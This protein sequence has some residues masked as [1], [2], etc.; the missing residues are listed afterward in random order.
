M[1][2]Y[3]VIE[4]VLNREGGNRIKGDCP[5]CKLGGIIYEY[6]STNEKFVSCQFCGYRLSRTIEIDQHLTSLDPHHRDISKTDDKGQLVYD[7]QELKGFGVSNIDMMGNVITKQFNEPITNKDIEEFCEY[8]VDPKVAKL[9]SYLT[10]WNDEFNKVILEIGH[11]PNSISA[12]L[13]NK[14]IQESTGEL[15]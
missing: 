15:D 9:G 8:Y 10:S 2:Q 4:K 1:N 11:C 12:Y 5:Q 3:V 7:I 6:P 13:Y 14:N